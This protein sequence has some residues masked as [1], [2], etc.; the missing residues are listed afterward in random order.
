VEDGVTGVLVHEATSSALARGLRT[1]LEA[2]RAD[3]GMRER[4]RREAE[5]Y[6]WSDFVQGVQKVLIR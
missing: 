5:T 3:P 6:R 1:A 4:C 2:L